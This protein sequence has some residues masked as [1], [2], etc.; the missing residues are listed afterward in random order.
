M[1]DKK[2]YDE[3]ELRRLLEHA[4]QRAFLEQEIT[5]YT[6][7]SLDQYIMDIFTEIGI[8]AGYTYEMICDFFNNLRY[9]MRKGWNYGR[10]KAK[11]K[12]ALARKSID[13]RCGISDES[14]DEEPATFDDV[15]LSEN[16][17]EET[18]ES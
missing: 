6:H 17:W 13:E 14:I 7:R 16:I 11:S 8:K 4:K 10:E 5:D 15:S 2:Q 9:G 18:D 1:N 3:E 12:N